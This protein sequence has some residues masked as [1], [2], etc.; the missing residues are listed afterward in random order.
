[1]LS[2]A[3]FE[4][5]NIYQIYIELLQKKP[6]QNMQ[7]WLFSFSISWKKWPETQNDIPLLKCL[8]LYTY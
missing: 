4:S 1:M 3:L 6:Q 7:A 5:F 8:A 2:K